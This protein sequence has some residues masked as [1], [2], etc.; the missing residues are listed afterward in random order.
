MKTQEFLKH[1][2]IA[3]NPFAEEDA[4]M[5]EACSDLMGTHDLMS[6]KPVILESDYA[7]VQARGLLSKLIR[8]ETSA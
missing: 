7:P 1:H 8:L 5:I 2:G 3:R 6:L 4:P